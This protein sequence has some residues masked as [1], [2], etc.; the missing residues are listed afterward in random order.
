MREELSFGDGSSSWGSRVTITDWNG[1]IFG[2][3]I[4]GDPMRL[5]NVERMG[6]ARF[7]SQPAIV[8]NAACSNATSVPKACWICQSGGEDGR[9]Q[10][11]ARLEAYQRIV[12]LGDGGGNVGT[13]SG[14]QHLNFH[15]KLMVLAG[16][17]RLVGALTVTPVSDCLALTKFFCNCC[18]YK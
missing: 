15:L 18:S 5:E 1:E 16:V 10:V 12:F 3:L 2:Y 6:I 14:Q 4:T 7:F 11:M 13:S 8:N 17:I 9:E